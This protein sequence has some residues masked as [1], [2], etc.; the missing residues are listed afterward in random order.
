MCQ[1]GSAVIALS[2][3]TTSF[4]LSLSK[5]R[6]WFDKPVLSGAEGLPT[7]GALNARCSND[8]VFILRGAHV[9]GH[10]GF[11]RRRESRWRG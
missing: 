9:N 5:G 3:D 7:N 1:S 8:S 4:T 2:I 6:S 10:G 11:P